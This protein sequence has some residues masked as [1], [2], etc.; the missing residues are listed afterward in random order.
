MAARTSIDTPVAGPLLPL[1]SFRSTGQVPGVRGVTFAP[2]QILASSEIHKREAS[3]TSTGTNYGK[4]N[5]A[6]FGT[7]N[8]WPY[9]IKF[10]TPF[11]FP[12][13]DR[14][15]STGKKVLDAGC[16][17]G[18][19]S[20]Y[21]SKRGANVYGID[22]QPE[23]VQQ[24]KIASLAQ[25]LS[26]KARFSEGNVGALLF[27]DN[28]F[29]FA[30][31]INVACNL[32]DEVLRSHMTEFSRVLKLGG[33]AVITVPISLD[34]PFSCGLRPEEELL[35]EIHAVLSEMPMNPTPDKIQ[36]AL[37][38]FEE[39]LSATFTIEDGRLILITKITPLEEGQEIWRK[40][41]N[42]VI[43]NRFYSEKRYHR[44]I[45]EANLEIIK[46]ERPSF[47]SEEEMREYNEGKPPHFRLGP[48]YIH[49]SPF[50]IYHLR[51]PE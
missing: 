27:E 9:A 24:A 26:S 21:G 17:V 40:L 14:M 22:L 2:A 12:D 15:G 25:G 41:P 7:S 35:A 11:F 51:K 37:G 44:A 45:V 4:L 10:L 3:H 39:M 48:E 20:L 16:G 42:M 19:W 8:N 38:S 18:L 6:K 30:M 23:M 49:S 46:E 50:A 5:V 29:D 36:T 34:V 28:S 33:E 43:P 47:A 13:L 31:S 32:P 1:L